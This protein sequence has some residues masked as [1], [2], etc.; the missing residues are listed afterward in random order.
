MPYNENHFTF[1]SDENGVNN[2]YAG[3]FTTK[4]EELDTLVLIAGELFRNPSPKEVD[5]LL[6]VYKRGCG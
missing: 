1:A 3:F 5:S 2:R 6:K 4:K